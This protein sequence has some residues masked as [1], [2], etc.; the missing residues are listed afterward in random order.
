MTQE[1][2]VNSLVMN[3]KVVFSR[4]TE[5]LKKNEMEISD[6]KNTVSEI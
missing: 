3:R 6:L 5:T 2:K 1:V 4:K